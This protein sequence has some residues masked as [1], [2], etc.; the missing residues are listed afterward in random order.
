MSRC[1][2]QTPPTAP[3]TRRRG[4]AIRGSGSAPVLVLVAAGL[5]IWA[6]TSQ[7]DSRRARSRRSSAAAGARRY[8]EGARRA[9][10]ELEATKKDCAEAE[11]ERDRRLGTGPAVVA[12]KALYD[13]VAEELD[14]TNQDLGATQQELEAAEKKATQ[15]EQDAKAAKQATADAGPRRRRRRRRRIRRR[16]SVKAAQSKAEVAADCAKALH[17]GVRRAVRGRQPD[18]PGAGDA[19]QLAAVTATCKAHSRARRP[20]GQA[21]GSSRLTG[22]SQRPSGHAD[23]RCRGPPPVGD[24]ALPSAGGALLR[25]PGLERDVGAVVGTAFGIEDPMLRHRRPIEP[26]WRRSFVRPPMPSGGSDPVFGRP[27]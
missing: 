14:A 20:T 10:K 11:S 25:S 1:R 21:T 4:K 5:L 26:I 17:L 23:D 2:R 22:A 8:A 19:E 12:G 16:R 27:S 18:G 3:R 9:K 6:L 24:S 13:E 15:A 7:S